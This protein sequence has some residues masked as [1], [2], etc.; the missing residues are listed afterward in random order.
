MQ[1]CLG[2]GGLGRAAF[3]GSSQT[4]PQH[5]EEDISAVG[6]ADTKKTSGR[7]L[8]HDELS[9][10]ERLKRRIQGMIKIRRGFTI[11]SGV[12]DHVMPKGRLAWILIV[13]SAGSRRVLHYV[14]GSGTRLPNM[15]QQVVRF[16]TE[17]GTWATWTFQVAGIHKPFGSEP[18]PIDHGWRVVL[19]MDA[20][21]SPRVSEGS[22]ALMLPLIHQM[23]NRI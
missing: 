3:D 4:I 20:A 5:S 8:A 14:A 19:Y 6:V 1:I 22:L 10:A 13:A 11:D 16:P 9:L 17:N 15:G 23:T 12:A 21:L 2:R 18:K 7:P